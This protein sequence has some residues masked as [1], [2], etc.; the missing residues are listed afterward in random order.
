[1]NGCMVWLAGCGGAGEREAG[2]SVWGAEEAA[3]R[4][5]WWRLLRARVAGSGCW[6]GW[7]AR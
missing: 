3:R 5:G 4:T 2:E 6:L 1:V 7:A